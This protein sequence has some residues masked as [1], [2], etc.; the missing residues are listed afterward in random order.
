MHNTRFPGRATDLVHAG[1]PVSRRT[2]LLIAAISMA[3]GVVLAGCQTAEQAKPML[4]GA[5]LLGVDYLTIAKVVTTSVDA[6]IPVVAAITTTVAADAPPTVTATPPAS[7]ISVT[8]VA[9]GTLAMTGTP[10]VNASEVV[11]PE[12]YSPDM[13]VTIAIPALDLRAPVVPMGWELILDHGKTTTRWLV[14]TDAVGWAVN[15]AGAGEPG[16]V[17]IVGHQALGEA[18]FRP[19]ALGEI[20]PGQEIDL[21]A[22]N[23]KRYSYKVSVESAPLPAIG[24]TADE[25]ARA[26]AYVEQGNTPKLTLI[27]GWP[28]DT[29]T[30]RVFV[31]A[32]LVGEKQ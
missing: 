28:A 21:L 32:D 23:G 5:E 30:H 12:S 2:V 16:N 20:E 19:L 24:A 3:L 8:P 17:I 6:G 11:T 7:A 1:P 22:A 4:V 14:P 13:P 27:T 31:V 18:L 26:A 9:T 10:A 25:K 15:S 29:S